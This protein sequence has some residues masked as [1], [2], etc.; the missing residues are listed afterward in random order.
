MKID[1]LD[2]AIE[3]FRQING[4]G[5]EN[6]IFLAQADYAHIGEAGLFFK[7]VIGRVLN[8]LTLGISGL[9]GALF[10]TAVGP[11]EAR[12]EYY[13]KLDLGVLN[14]YMQFI[15]N[16]TEDSVAIIPVH[17][18]GILHWKAD[19]VD[20]FL[21]HGRVIPK[22]VIE[23]IQVKRFLLITPTI[24]GVKIKLIDGHL[25]EFTIATNLKTTP[26][27]VDNIKSFREKHKKR[28]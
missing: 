4:A 8:R 22:N 7:E 18:K 3:L 15:I 10:H 28:K 11:K 5:N 26:Y 17:F 1:T 27:N 25:L 9:I 19:E 6:C 16:E 23:K 12:Q 14:N 13:Q 2:N 24:K 20:F 21:E